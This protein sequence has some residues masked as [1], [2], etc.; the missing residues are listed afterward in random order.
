FLTI[1]MKKQTFSNKNNKKMSEKSD[2]KV[3]VFEMVTGVKKGQD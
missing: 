1:I 3:F 2:I